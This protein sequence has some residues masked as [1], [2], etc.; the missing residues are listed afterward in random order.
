MK[1]KIKNQIIIGRFIWKPM[2]NL[3]LETTDINMYATRVQSHYN[4]GM[5]IMQLRYL[6]LE[7]K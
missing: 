5:N 4:R 3:P 2:S 6:I 1:N 7:S